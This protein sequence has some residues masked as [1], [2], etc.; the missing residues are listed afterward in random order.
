LANNNVG[1]KPDKNLHPNQTDQ[2]QLYPLAQSIAGSMPW[3]S[4]LFGGKTVHL[5][6][7]C[8]KNSRNAFN[9]AKEQTGE[10][11]CEILRRFMALYIL[12]VIIEKHVLGNTLMRV[13]NMPLWVD[14]VEYNQ[15]F[16][17]P[18]RVNVFG[19]VEH[20]RRESDGYPCELKGAS[21]NLE[22]LPKY[23]DDVC[24]PQRCP[25]KSCFEYVKVL[26]GKV[27]SREWE[28][29]DGRGEN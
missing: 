26:R 16:E 9:W 3:F 21:V 11:G 25:N 10:D 28:G 7:D 2:N 15:F 6:F 12:R 24:V 22:N 13:V 4:D 17:R 29:S 8:P 20:A 27:V 18:R 1:K 5:S 23:F 14:R 19:K